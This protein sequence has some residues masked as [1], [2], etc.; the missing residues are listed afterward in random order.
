LKLN[1]SGSTP[2]LRAIIQDRDGMLY[3]LRN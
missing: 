2:E 3:T 1:Q